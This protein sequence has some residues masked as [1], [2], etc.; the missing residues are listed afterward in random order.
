VV[1]AANLVGTTIFAAVVSSPGLFSDAVHQSMLDIGQEMMD[2]DFWPKL[3]KAVFAGWLIALMVWLLPSARSARLLVVMILT[4]VVAVCG[5][6]H[7]IAGSVDAAFVVFAG[8]ASLGD[9]FIRFLAPTLIGNSIGGMAL[10]AL[11][12]YAPLAP[13]FQDSSGD[14]DS[15]APR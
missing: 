14:A 10:A 7:I 3:V 13:E 2:G 4:Y 15:G 8:H 12:N 6:P 9:Y 5:F 1:L 11:L